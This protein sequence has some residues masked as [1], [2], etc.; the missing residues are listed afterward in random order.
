MRIYKS[1][2]SGFW[3]AQ[4]KENGWFCFNG[5]IPDIDS[6]QLCAGG[7]GC[8]E[9]KEAWNKSIEIPKD[10]EGK[11]NRFFKS[12]NNYNNVCDFIKTYY[13]EVTQEELDKE[14]K[15]YPD[16]LQ[17]TLDC[18][19]KSCNTSS[20][21]IDYY[22][23]RLFYKAL[24]HMHEWNNDKDRVVKY[25]IAHD[26]PELTSFDTTMVDIFDCKHPTRRFLLHEFHSLWNNKKLDKWIDEAV[27]KY[28]D[29]KD[30]DLA[31]YYVRDK[32][33]EEYKISE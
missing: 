17:L 6:L 23:K 20:F 19:K 3:F 7:F 5:M 1:K 33:E 22:V 26:I 29:E 21:T 11:F 16:I 27:K 28:P 13:P 8:E 30:Y 31:Y 4:T 12:K 32:Q 25:V 18:I 14:F 24:N 9:E 10:E 2:H 15:H